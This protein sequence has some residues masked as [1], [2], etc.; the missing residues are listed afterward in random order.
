MKL[1]LEMSIA[2]MI[3]LPVW[4]SDIGKI[5]DVSGPDVQID[6]SG[7]VSYASKNFPIESM[8]IVSTAAH[9]VDIDFIDNTKV[10]VSDHSRLIIDDFVFDPNSNDA[11]KLGLKVG[12]G[13]VRYA[14]GQIAKMNHQNV[15]I[16]TPTATIA[17]RGTDFFMTVD[18]IGRSFVALVPSCDSQGNCKTGVIDVITAQGQVTLDQAFTATAVMN[19]RGLP[20]PPVSIPPDVRA[21]NNTMIISQ[22]DALKKAILKQMS[23]TETASVEQAEIESASNSSRPIDSEISVGTQNLIIIKKS[24]NNIAGYRVTNGS[25]IAWINLPKGNTAALTIVQQNIS[26]NAN[27]NNG[28]SNKINIRQSK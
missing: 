28:E 17:V 1:W 7:Q 25:D 5:S 16:Q 20:T 27:L 10:T 21:I 13:T 23:S 18:E 8:D 15:D 14:S 12:L 11:S 24:A 3:S 4:A 2:V 6:R 19:P 22:P 9:A 26:A